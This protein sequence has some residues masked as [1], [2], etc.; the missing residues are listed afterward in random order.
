[1]SLA[2]RALAVALLASVAAGGCGDSGAAD[3]RSTPAATPS[4]APSA[5]ATAAPAAAAPARAA[6]NDWN[7]FG[8]DAA[9]TSRAPPGIAPGRVA[10]LRQ[11]S[12][13]LPGTVDASPIY[14][15]GVRVDGK[16]RDV[17]V[18][19]TTYGRTLALDAASGRTLWQF[20][21]RSYADVAG[22]PQITNATPLSDRRWVWAASPDGRIH[23]LSLADGREAG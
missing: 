14:L 7:R 12:I 9:R 16:R 22:S 15:G 18:L 2:S 3:P 1:M 6:A 10:G 8:Y 13:A 21:P 11:R 5:T 4:A 23:K 20:T 17:I 19:T